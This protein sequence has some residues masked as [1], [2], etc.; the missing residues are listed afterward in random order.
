MAP[1]KEREISSS[2]ETL[3]WFI[4]IQTSV[5]VLFIAASIGFAMNFHGRLATVEARPDSSSHNQVIQID[6][7]SVS[8]LAREIAKQRKLINDP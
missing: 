3:K 1:D 7:D 5:M 4:G 8:E 6:R 2:L